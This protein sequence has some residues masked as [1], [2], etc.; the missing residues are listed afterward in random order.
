MSLIFIT[1]D[2]QVIIIF[3]WVTT[4]AIV[5]THRDMCSCQKV[6][7][8]RFFFFCWTFG[9]E[10]PD[11]TRLGT[12]FAENWSD[13]HVSSCNLLPWGH[14]RRTWFDICSLFHVIYCLLHFCSIDRNVLPSFFALGCVQ[15]PARNTIVVSGSTLYCDDDYNSAASRLTW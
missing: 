9:S 1:T 13:F 8:F 3:W 15:L 11:W 6:S 4:P 2:N 12:P 7:L 14:T 5:W 10:V